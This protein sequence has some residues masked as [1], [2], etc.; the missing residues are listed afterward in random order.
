MQPSPH[1]SMCVKPALEEAQSRSAS[2]W[3]WWLPS[4]R[5]AMPNRFE[6]FVDGHGSVMI[7]HV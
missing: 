2:V 4:E 7:C 1:R 5:V 3:C 6:I